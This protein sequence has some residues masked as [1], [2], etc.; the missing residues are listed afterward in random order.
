ML[1]SLY[2]LTASVRA[3]G[4][5]VLLHGAPRLRG[6][7]Q[8][9]APLE[10]CCC[11]LGINPTFLSIAA[12][13]YKRPADP[14]Q[15]ICFRSEVNL[16]TSDRSSAAIAK[17]EVT[18]TETSHLTSAIF[19]NLKITSWL[20]LVSTAPNSCFPCRR[21]L[22]FPLMSRLETNRSMPNLGNNPWPSRTSR[23]AHQTTHRRQ[24]CTDLLTGTKPVP[25]FARHNYYARHPRRPWL[26]SDA[27][28]LFLDLS[29]S[30]DTPSRKPLWA[31][32]LNTTLGHGT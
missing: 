30:V 10:L 15:R 22:L 4:R 14:H 27:K 11:I 6:R 25:F 20:P 18:G 19:L 21:H 12:R 8:H 28:S 3:Q 31:H 26:A 13:R 17:R 9:S 16:V 1:P 24:P 2:Y 29:Q 5:Q 32:G 23:H 7:V